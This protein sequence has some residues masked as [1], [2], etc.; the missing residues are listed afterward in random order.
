MDLFGV[1]SVPFQKRP[2]TKYFLQVALLRGARIQLSLKMFLCVFDSLFLNLS[3]NIFLFLFYADVALLISNQ[4]VL[5]FRYSCSLLVN[6]DFYI[7]SEIRI[8]QFAIILSTKQRP[9][10]NV[11][12]NIQT[13]SQMENPI[14]DVWNTSCTTPKY[15]LGGQRFHFLFVDLP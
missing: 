8:R 7:V 6:K 13:N 9:L 2:P 5:V 3:V 1:K 15:M 10:T 4:P 12:T 14:V 11:H